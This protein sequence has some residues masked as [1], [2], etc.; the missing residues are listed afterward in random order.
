M[1]NHGIYSF[2]GFESMAAMA[3]A[4]V[5]KC[6]SHGLEARFAPFSSFLRGK[7]TSAMNGERL[8]QRSC[9]GASEIAIA[10][11]TMSKVLSAPY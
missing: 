1:S 5:T 4:F 10:P 6:L 11:V 7:A 8:Q 9:G 3:N 2:E